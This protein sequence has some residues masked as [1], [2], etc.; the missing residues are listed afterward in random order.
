MVNGFEVFSILCPNTA[1]I[2]KSLA[3]HMI[4]NIL[5][6]SGVAMTQD[7]TSLAFISSNAN[8]HASSKSNFVSFSNNLHNGLANLEKS[9]KY[10]VKTLSKKAYDSFHRCRWNQSVNY[11]DFGLI[12]F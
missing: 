1:P 11:R 12:N 8:L 3:S 7:I 10:Y 9:N 4:S 5:F 6:P 2:A